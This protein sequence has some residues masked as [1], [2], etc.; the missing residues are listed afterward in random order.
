M[1]YYRVEGHPGH[2]QPD[3][4]GGVDDDTAMAPPQVGERGVRRVH[5]PPEV[6]VLHGTAGSNTVIAAAADE[7]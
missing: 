2:G 3:L 1:G 5:V 6:D 4:D 7:I